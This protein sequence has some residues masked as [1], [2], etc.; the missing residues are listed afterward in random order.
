MPLTMG[1]L[2]A[3]LGLPFN[4]RSDAERNEVTLALDHVLTDLVPHGVVDYESEDLTIDYPPTARRFRLEPLDSL[5][6]QIGAGY[7]EADDEVLLAALARLSE[8]PGLDHADVA[9]VRAEDV[10]VALGWDWHGSRAAAI[11]RNLNEQDLVAGS[12]FPGFSIRA[13]VTYAGLVRALLTATPDYRLPPRRLRGRPKGSRTVTRDQILT[14]FQQLR[15]Q[16]GRA[17]TQRELC[18]SLEPRIEVRTLKAALDA[19]GLPWP[20]E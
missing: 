1:T 4:E 5:W 6:P 3:E 15:T 19:Y 14:T 11:Y 16:Y 9:E 12:M 13:R 17:P 8:R 10:F 18:L 7:L 20:I 2:A